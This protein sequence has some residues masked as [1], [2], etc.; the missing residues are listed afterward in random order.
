MTNQEKY[1]KIYVNSFDKS[2]Y[3]LSDTEKTARYYV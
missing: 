1:L 3:E 2:I